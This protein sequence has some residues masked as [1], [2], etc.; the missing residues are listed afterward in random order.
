MYLKRIEIFG[1]KSFANPTTIVCNR[2]IT[3]ILGPNGCG[4][5]NVV[6]AIRWV[7]GEQSSKNMRASKMEDVIFNGTDTKKPLNLAEV[8]LLLDNEDGSIPLEFPE[9]SIKRRIHRSGDNEYFLNNR[10]CRLKDIRELLFDTGIGRS[11]Y[12]ILEQGKIDKILS[13]RPE[14]R[15]QIFEEAAGITK[16]KQWELEAS[17]KLD[18]N[19]EN[20]HRVQDMFREVKRSHSTLKV[21][22]ERA[23]VYRTIRDE[24]FLLEVDLQ[25]TRVKRYLDTRKAKRKDLEK[26]TERVEEYRLSLEKIRNKQE[27]EMSMQREIEEELLD[28]QKRLYGIT[29]V[30]ESKLSQ[31]EMLRERQDELSSLLGGISERFTRFLEQEQ[32]LTGESQ[33]FEKRRVDV[34]KSVAKNLEAQKSLHNQYNGLQ[35]DRTQAQES[36]ER[37]ELLF[38]DFGKKLIQLQESSEALTAQI[39]EAINSGLGESEVGDTNLE[40]RRNSITQRIDSLKALLA[41]SVSTIQEIQRTGSTDKLLTQAVKISEEGLASLEALTKEVADLYQS[42]PSFLVDLLAP[43]GIFA[44]KSTLQEEIRTV[45]QYEEESREKIRTLRQ[46]IAQCGERIEDLAQQRER[47]RVEGAELAGELDR[48]DLALSQV[49]KQIEEAHRMRT[50]L[51]QERDHLTQ[52]LQKNREQ[53]GEMDQEWE[54]MTKEEHTLQGQLEKLRA[55]LNQVDEKLEQKHSRIALKQEQYVKSQGKVDRLTYE[56]ETIGHELEG[57]YESFEETHSRSLKEFDSRIFSIKTDGL[58]EK[59]QKKRSKLQSLG[60]INF[61]APEEFKEVHE[62]Y[63]FLDEQLKDLE[64]A[65]A[66]LE[67][68]TKEMRQTASER[69]ISQYQQIQKNFHS[70]FRRLFAGGRGELKLVDPEHVLESGIDIFAQPPGKVLENISLLSGGERSLT[71]V[72]LLFAT[73]M[74]KPSPFCILDEMDAA[75][76]E[77]NIGRFVGVLSEF[78]ENS[79]FIII[80]HSKK[81]VT[82]AQSLIGITMEEPGITKIITLKLGDNESTDG[83]RLVMK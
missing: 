65:C 77:A 78:S 39:I 64:K 68:V 67:A 17:R 58:K 29:H 24:I 71:A 12:S 2:G 19:K 72:A 1:F 11:S 44:K 49:T 53:M 31:L 46:T 42:L 34:T 75:L 5:S 38:E 83:K 57:L 7:L 69:F 63:M 51:D 21:Q 79:Q 54:S 73:Y 13:S 14:E 55:S 82:G 4:K 27:S 70:M 35:D 40:E 47:L 20:M 76:D 3:A 45:R 62:R 43:Q 28:I 15:R 8:T 52:Q 25:L 30:K 59:L 48:L 56:L 16:Y 36:L 23:E 50:S 61:A 6:D 60:Q 41:D 80:T 18:K 26:E 10:Q 22:A 33:E 66:D 32:Q 37:E 9:I 74:V 81:T